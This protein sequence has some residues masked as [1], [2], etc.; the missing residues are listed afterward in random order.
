MELHWSKFQVLPVQ[1]AGNIRTPDGVALE[2]TA[3]MQYLGA[4]LAADGDQNHEL[5]RKMAIAKKDFFVLQKLWSHSSLTWQRKLRI[6]ASLI[7]SRLLYSL[8]SACLIKV[9]LRRLDGFQ[10]R[11]LRYI[12]GVKPS[13]ISRVANA[14]VLARTG[15]TPASKLLLLRQLQLFGKVLRVD[16]SHP[17][18]ENS[19]IPGTMRATTER[20]VR[21]I[22][23][24][25]KEFVPD[26]LEQARILFGDV[27]AAASS[28]ANR[29][30]W[31][32]A[33]K[34]KLQVK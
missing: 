17:L 29:Q 4:H 25:C 28:A 34:H 23:R 11:C 3:C 20:Y 12:I 21:R 27:G 6:Y 7:E 30:S 13:W 33:L 22:G 26:M 1:S 15:H 32:Q 24:P 16:A 19:F 14:D 31:N 18:R 10:N 2:H 9:Q 5:G 8:A